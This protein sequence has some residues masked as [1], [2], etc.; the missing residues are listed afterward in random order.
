MAYSYQIEPGVRIDLID[1][2]DH[3]KEINA[4]LAHDLLNEF[5]NGIDEIILHPYLY[6][7]ISKSY[8]KLSLKRF[9]YKIVFQIKQEQIT[10]VA[11]AHHKQKPNYWQN[12]K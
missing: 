3:Y 11:L 7:I 1:A 4:Q 5:Y 6:Q 9:P 2:L 10:I 12:R 8:R